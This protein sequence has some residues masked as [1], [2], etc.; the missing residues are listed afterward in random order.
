MSGTPKAPPIYRP[1]TAHGSVQS[2]MALESRPA[3]P[4]YRPQQAGASATQPVAQQIQRPGSTPSQYV[5]SQPVWIASGCQQ[6]R[7]NIKG[8]PT[9]VGS[10]DVHYQQAGKAFISDLEV[11]QAHR[12][13]GVATMLMKAAMESARRHGSMATE[14]EA[15][16]GP[17]SIS[18]HALVGMYQKLGFKNS[19]V[20]RR[21]NPK[22]SMR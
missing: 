1:T 22:L 12:R 20:T 8:S 17:G 21:G 19:G 7:V 18:K 11:N 10:V 9:P 13:H 5:L 4:V 3:P 16:P 6:I 14:L 2:K 15:N